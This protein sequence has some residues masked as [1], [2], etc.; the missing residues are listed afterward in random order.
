M[1]NMDDFNR[2]TAIVLAKLYDAFPQPMMRFR[3]RWR[4]WK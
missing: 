2:C 4:R 1:S 3:S